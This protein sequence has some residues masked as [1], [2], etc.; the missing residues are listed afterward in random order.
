MA[1]LKVI[2][3]LATAL[4]FL[5]GGEV[6]G[7]AGPPTYLSAGGQ[8]A[9]WNTF[10]GSSR[11]DRVNGITVDLN[12]HI[13]VTGTS[14]NIWGEG[15]VVN[16]F[17]GENNSNA[18]VAKLDG[19]GV[20]MWVTFLGSADGEDSGSGIALDSLGHVYVIGTSDLPWGN[21]P[22]RAHGGGGSDA[23]LAKLDA[24]TGLLLK[25]TFLGATNYQD[26]GRGLAVQGADVFVVGKGNGS[27]LYA[28][29][30]VRTYSGE[31]DVFAARLRTED[32]G[33]LWYTFLGSF[34]AEDDHPGLAVDGANNVYVSGTSPSTWGAPRRPHSQTGTSRDAFAAKL[35][36]TGALQWNTF[37]GSGGQFYGQGIAVDDN[38]FVFVAGFG[39]G[40]WTEQ[41]LTGYSGGGDGFLAQ[42][43]NDGI[44]QWHT[45]LG[46]AADDRARAL[47][48]D[49]NGDIL[50]IGDSGAGWGN[51]INP[52]GSGD[53]Q[54]VFVAKLHGTGEII[55]NTFLGADNYY[56]FG[57]TLAV[58]SGKN[59]YVAGESQNEW[60]TP[61]R[62]YMGAYDVFVARLSYRTISGTATYGIFPLGGVAV[63][64]TTGEH[65][66]TNSSGFYQITVPDGWS[67]SI[68][69]TLIPYLFTPASMAYTELGS[70]VVQDFVSTQDIKTISGFIL[71]G[72][73]PLAEV[74]V[75]AVSDNPQ[76]PPVQ[77]VSDANG[78]YNI[79]VQ[80]GWS[81]TVTPFLPGY[82]FSPPDRPYVSIASN[83]EN[84][85]FDATW[86]VY[87]SGTTGLEGVVLN[88]LPGNPLTGVGGD[89]RIRVRHNWTGTVTPTYPNR[90]FTTITN[91]PLGQSF[92][93]YSNVTAEKSDQDYQGRQAYTVSGRIL[94]NGNPLAGITLTA[95]GLPNTVTTTTDEN[96]YYHFTLDVGWHGTVTPS[97]PSYLFEDALHNDHIEFSPLAND[98]PG[99]DFSASWVVYISGTIKKANDEPVA[100]VRLNGVSNPPLTDWTGQYIVQTGY[101]WSGF[102]T[103]YLEGHRFAPET[104]NYN[105][106]INLQSG[107]D[108]LA[109]PVYTI[110]GFITEGPHPVRGV[111]VTANPGGAF[112][113]TDDNGFYTLTVDE[114]WTGTVT[115][116]L[117]GY[118]FFQPN[119]TYSQVREDWPNQD[120][121]ATWMV[122]ITGTITSGVSGLGGVHLHGLP[123]DQHTDNDGNY[124]VRV[125]YDWVGTVS[126]A[127]VGYIFNPAQIDYFGTVGELTGQDYLAQDWPIRTL[128]GHIR[129]SGAG[130][131]DVPVTVSP[132]EPTATDENGWYQVR[133]NKGW[134]G[135]VVPLAHGL[136]FS[137][138]GRVYANLLEDLGDQDFSVGSKIY[139][140]LVLRP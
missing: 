125:D 22:T 89:Y 16:P 43:D 129:A 15:Q 30:P 80:A 3:W 75:T 69:P 65:T 36:P 102:I 45:F 41:P 95:S 94:R 97:H 56:D 27:W 131:A 34:E 103:P 13:Y 99:Q 118:T 38:G 109:I 139:L 6:K 123:G 24:N 53:P 137:P 108:Y 48:L 135:T 14:L 106:I 124:R 140:P 50:V 100:G 136:S 35:N 122:Y 84:Q 9:V 77:T 12:G 8:V 44:Y 4:V 49:A 72:T 2:F 10:L 96:G 23:F 114:D 39:D 62:G 29:E 64:L 88:G 20:L 67:G 101:S 66:S 74:T 83:R 37:L 107:Q 26:Y 73:A 40:E 104:R 51:P 18:F 132:G 61:V 68:T 47:T 134:S 70:D 128:S 63:D 85:D 111:T 110:S 7:A 31:G 119:H 25:H 93:A 133:V 126:P 87:I 57:L 28:P 81:G 121:S 79:S 52:Y 42:L 117:N 11:E 91:P 120:F 130:L 92:R 98:L 138:A 90:L 32:L 112:T 5:Q 113:V 55:W 58:D 33:I 105:N 46:S 19:A 82:D 54:E 17:P 1:F 21:D 127:L 115:P 116:G 71:E 60:G 59:V 78:Y 76:I 86:T